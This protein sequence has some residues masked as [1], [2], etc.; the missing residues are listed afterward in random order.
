MSRSGKLWLGEDAWGGLKEMIRV[1]QIAEV[2]LSPARG[3]SRRSTAKRS[4]VF[5]C[6]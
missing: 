4:C 3:K 5:G 1:E 6:A 2:R